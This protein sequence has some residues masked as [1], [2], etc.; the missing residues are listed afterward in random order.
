MQDL[1]PHETTATARR[2]FTLI[3]LLVVIAIIAI[4]AGMLLPA[5][6]SAKEAGKRA[7]CLN[8]NR[9]LGLSMM[10]YTMENDGHL[11]PRSHPVPGDPNHP[12]WP[13]RLQPGYLDLR[14]LICPSDNPIAYS[15]TVDLANYAADGAP[16]SY[17]YNAWNDYYIPLYA[18]QGVGN[19][20]RAAAKTNELSIA[21]SCIREPAETITFGEKDRNS[22][23]WYFDYET[24]EDVTQLD[25]SAHGNRGRQGS[26]SGGS[27]YSF[28]DGSARYLRFGSS[29]EP[30]NLWA[31]T[32]A[33]RNLN[34]GPT[35]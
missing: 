6:A 7:K 24:Y 21:E 1:S 26:T 25:Q 2:G 19:N 15:N 8:N 35:P 13:F 4:L 27:N 17:I 23:H 14:I 22:M 28:A 16:R 12:R 10:M 3:E 18:A 29:V 34:S 9:Q 31:I 33:W 32:A 11:P 20:W 30:I 5:L